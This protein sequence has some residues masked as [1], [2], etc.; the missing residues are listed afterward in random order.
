MIT[1]LIC[2]DFNSIYLTDKNELFAFG[3]N[4]NK[5]LGCATNSITKFKK[6]DIGIK[7]KIVY[8]SKDSDNIFLVTESGEIYISGFTNFSIHIKNRLISGFEKWNINLKVKKILKI[9]D[10]VY[11]IDSSNNLFMY[12]EYNY[13]LLLN[14]VKDIQKNID[15]LFIFTNDNKLYTL[16]ITSH[17]NEGNLKEIKLNFNVKYFSLSNF[18]VYAICTKGNLYKLVNDEF[19]KVFLLDK[20]VK[21]ISTETNNIVLL[22]ESGELFESI[23][24]NA[25]I[26]TFFR[27]KSDDLVLGCKNTDFFVRVNFDKP[28]KSIKCTN[29]CTSILTE[30]SEIYIKGF[31]NKCKYTNKISMLSTNKYTKMDTKID[32]IVDIFVTTKYTLILNNKDELFICGQIPTRGTASGEEA[33]II[34]EYT[35]IN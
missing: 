7:E 30:N 22:T 27:P 33:Y 23:R 12:K 3:M 10:S 14:N 31:N 9:F 17:T 25:F 18:V 35:K 32:N 19:I 34:P 2:D 4:T 13:S 1:K 6:I 24:N 20:K 28:I 26:Q 11:I 21:Y 29:S 8:I 5:V 16:D 15:S